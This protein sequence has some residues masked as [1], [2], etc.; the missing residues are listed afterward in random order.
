MKFRVSRPEKL[1]G[2]KGPM[3]A[4]L[5]GGK[6]RTEVTYKLYGVLW[7]RADKRNARECADVTTIHPK[8][9]VQV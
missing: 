5:F 2:N 8:P 1:T 7:S 9:T 6:S 4:S 3:F